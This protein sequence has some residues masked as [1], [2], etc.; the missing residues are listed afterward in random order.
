MKE[1]AYYTSLG[2]D[3]VRCELCPHHCTIREAGHGLCLTR[4]NRG[5][6]LIASNYCRPVST[7]VDP[8]EK[9]PLFHFYPG[10]SIFS[11]G[12]SGCNFKCGFCQN[13]EISQQALGV[14]EISV[15]RF[16]R[17]IEGSDSIGIAYTYTEPSIWFETIMD[18]GPKVRERGL[19]NVLV[20]NGYLAEPPLHDLLTFVDAM[21]VDIKSMN[22]DFYR[23]ICKGSLAPVLKT[24]EIAKKAGCHL[25][26]TNLLIP[27]ENDDPAETEELARFIAETLGTD[28]P[29][30]ISRYFPRFQMNHAPTPDKTL[31]NAWNIAAK[32]LDYVYLGNVSSGTKE[33]TLCPQCGALLVS[34]HGYRSS[35]TSL[36]GKNP[37]DPNGKPECMMCGRR[38][39][40][41][42]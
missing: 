2:P 7:A 29:L 30:H 22:P 35:V 10:S 31:E 38:I 3:G 21:N 4:E 1:A 41:V 40:I 17:M 37:V 8:I 5:G 24:C 32:R 28:T 34:R 20:T 39:D 13:F 11:T 23:R 33:Q 6:K 18:V 25:E 14:P 16:M 19:K 26:I 36:L 27:G 42:M 9:K 15:E 12:P